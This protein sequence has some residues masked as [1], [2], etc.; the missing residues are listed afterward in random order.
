MESNQYYQFLLGT[1]WIFTWNAIWIDSLNIIQH[2][3]TKNVANQY[4]Y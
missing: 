4:E 3:K 1:H 2:S